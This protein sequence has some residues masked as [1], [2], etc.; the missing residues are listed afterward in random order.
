MA[1]PSR[2]I[3]AVGGA[4]CHLH[5]FCGDRFMNGLATLA[6]SCS[7]SDALATIPA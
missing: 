5:V 3:V 7:A 1:T 4:D 6:A 2:F